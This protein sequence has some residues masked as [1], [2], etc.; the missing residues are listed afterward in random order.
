[1]EN[2][3]FRKRASKTVFRIE[4]H[5]ENWSKIH[6]IYSFHPLRSTFGLP[7]PPRLPKR[8]D[9]GTIFPD[10]FSVF[11]TGS[12]RL[13]AEAVVLTRNSRRHFAYIWF[14]LFRK[15]ALSLSS[16]SCARA[17][18]QKSPSDKSAS[19]NFRLYSRV[20]AS[21]V[22][23]V[24]SF[25]GGEI[26]LLFFLFSLFCISFCSFF[27]DEMTHDDQ[28]GRPWESKKKRK[29]RPTSKATLT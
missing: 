2:R 1:M 17:T 27:G 15:N 12:G 6:Q 22:P 10:W 28:N 23:V 4:N 18:V 19:R 20:S 7:C 11:R 25:P 26:G 16:L 9:C 5:T 29:R 8:A 14:Y 3:A 24:V 21:R 13:K